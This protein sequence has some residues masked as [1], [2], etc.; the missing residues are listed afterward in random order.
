MKRVLSFILLLF[1]LSTF[2][3]NSKEDIIGLL[4]SMPIPNS[5]LGYKNPQLDYIQRRASIDICML[6]I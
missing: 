6:N 4:G 3:Q 5:H 2:G 1:S